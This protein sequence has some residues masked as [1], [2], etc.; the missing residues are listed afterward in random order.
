MRT[1]EIKPVSTRLTCGLP[2][3]F[4]NLYLYFILYLLI[5]FKRNNGLILINIILENKFITLDLYITIIN[6]LYVTNE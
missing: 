3:F 1:K 4:F 6:L 2:V 5:F